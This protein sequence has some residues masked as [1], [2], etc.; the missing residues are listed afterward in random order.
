[1]T[2]HKQKKFDLTSQTTIIKK[3]LE[4]TISGRGRVMLVI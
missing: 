4:T 3:H 1:M 2:N